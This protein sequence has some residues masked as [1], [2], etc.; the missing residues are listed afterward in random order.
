MGVSQ[1]EPVFPRTPNG[2]WQA[3]RAARVEEFLEQS[4]HWAFRRLSSREG[5]TESC[6]SLLDCYILIIPSDLL[7]R[8][9]CG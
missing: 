2:I 1:A 3:A 6:Q 8:G 9:V 4:N 5:R 7:Y